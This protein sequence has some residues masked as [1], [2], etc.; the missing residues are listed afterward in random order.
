[1]TYRLLTTGFA[2]KQQH[3]KAILSTTT[4]VPSKPGVSILCNFDISFTLC[5]T[6][7]LKQFSVIKCLCAIILAVIDAS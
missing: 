6:T 5:T 4:F 7:C 3:C 2:T 1:M